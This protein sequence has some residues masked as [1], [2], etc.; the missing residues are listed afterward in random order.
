MVKC[1]IPIG[2]RDMT[3]LKDMLDPPSYYCRNDTGQSA[4][5]TSEKWPVTGQEKV[6]DPRS[7]I[8]SLS[9]PVLCHVCLPAQSCSSRAPRAIGSCDMFQRQRDVMDGEREGGR[10]SGCS[11]SVL[12]M[13]QTE[14][15]INE[16]GS[17]AGAGRAV[18][19]SARKKGKGHRSRSQPPRFPLSPPSLST[20]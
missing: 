3:A 13:L 2:C 11:F 19:N 14:Q 10:E 4:R 5:N 6:K 15:T 12:C 16:P 9:L 17:G 20:E 7:R 18:C 1:P 8:P